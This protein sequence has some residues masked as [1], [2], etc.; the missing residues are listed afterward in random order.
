MSVRS[1]SHSHS[2]LCEFYFLVRNN[3]FIHISWFKWNVFLVFFLHFIT[4]KDLEIRLKKIC[5][6]HIRAIGFVTAK[7]E[8]LPTMITDTFAL[9]T[10]RIYT[11]WITSQHTW[12]KILFQPL[13]IGLFGTE[14]NTKNRTFFGLF[15]ICKK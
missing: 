13:W 10:L 6:I 2:I 15:L 11:L 3:H 1:H 4:L 12:F 8:C 5:L 14:K 7:E 9:C